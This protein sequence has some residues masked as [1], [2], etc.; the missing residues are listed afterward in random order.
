MPGHELENFYDLL[1]SKISYSHRAGVFH[2]LCHTTV[3]VFQIECKRP[4]GFSHA[5]EM[6]KSA[7][8]LQS[9]VRPPVGPGQSSGGGQRGEAPGRSAHLCFENLLL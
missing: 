1:V 2:A 9:A 5:E 6:K 8:G 3:F 7:G 4:K